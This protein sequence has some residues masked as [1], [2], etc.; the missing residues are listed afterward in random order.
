MGWAMQSEVNFYFS[1]NKGRI[2][3]PQVCNSC[4]L[5][6]AHII[7]SGSGTNRAS[8]LCFAEVRPFHFLTQTLPANSQPVLSLFSLWGSNSLIPASIFFCSLYLILR[9]I[10][11]QAAVL[12]RAPGRYCAADRQGDQIDSTKNTTGNLK[13]QGMQQGTWPSSILVCHTFETGIVRSLLRRARDRQN[14][15]SCRFFFFALPNGF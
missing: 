7:L 1:C 14:F 8:P 13:A 10:L 6:N 12:P 2:L 11:F 5:W 3:K 9:Q 15:A 4:Q